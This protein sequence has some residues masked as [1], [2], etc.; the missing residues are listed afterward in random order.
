M[1]RGTLFPVRNARTVRLSLVAVGLACAAACGKDVT[2]TTS[3]DI[4]GDWR[5]AE[6]LGSSAQQ[7]TC[8][9]TIQVHIVQTGTSLTLQG[10]QY[11]YCLIGT[12]SIPLGDAVGVNGRLN[13]TRITFGDS[14]C[15]YTGDIAAGDATASGTSRCRLP[16]PGGVATAT[17]TWQARRADFTRPTAT[18]TLATTV[19]SHGDTLR[20]TVQASD[21]SQLAVIGDSVAYDRVVFSNDCLTDPPPSVD[22]AVVTGTSTQ[23]TFTHIVPGCSWYFRVVAF[24]RD[25]AGNRGDVHLQDVAVVLP[26]SQVSGTLDDTVY[27][28]GDTARIRLTATNTRG[29]SYVGYRWYIP[30]PA[31][32]DSIAVTGTSADTTLKLRIPPTAPATQLGVRVFARHRLGWLTESDLSYARTTDAIKLPLQRLTMPS[33]PRDFVYAPAGDRI[34][35]VDST[36]AVR[37][38]LL[39]PLSLGNVYAIAQPGTSL[40]VSPGEDSLLV[41]LAGQMTLAVISRT[42]STVN[43]PIINPDAI[44][45]WDPRRIRIVAGGAAARAMIGVGSGGA[46]GIVQLNLADGTQTNRHSWYGYGTFERT[47][48]RARILFIEDGGPIGSQLYIAATD[49]FLP[50]Q[51]GVVPIY[52]TYGQT[53]GDDAATKWLVGCQLLTA[54]MTPIRIFTDPTFFYY[55]PTAIAPDAS[56]AYCARTEA[57]MEFDVTSGNRVR[58]VWLP[59]PPRYLKAL[60][61]KRVLAISGRNL[62]LVTLP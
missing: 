34:F 46:G 38:V 62:Y 24:A 44:D 35:L 30:N 49:T 20:V 57:F 61:G 8:R 52:G 2:G 26:A 16:L 5:F 15:T 54:D 17:G 42:G 29:L 3:E 23:H 9:D 1:R 13:G 40:D 53:S 31:G 11:G 32:Q 58:A 14:N 55:G 37:E 4:N 45:I 10:Q 59:S 33:S 60:P 19:V 21:N 25:T 12:D 48:N 39:N 28:L 22:S 27:S 41:T 7:L 6:Q 50:R 43:V 56:S 18:A 51:S 47:G 36:A